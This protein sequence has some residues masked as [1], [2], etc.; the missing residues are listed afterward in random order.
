MVLS[1]LIMRKK[2]T[3]RVSWLFFLVL[4]L[5]MRS[6][7]SKQYR[8]LKTNFSRWIWLFF[9]ILVGNNAELYFS[10]HFHSH[11]IR[12][13]LF[14]CVQSLPPLIRIVGI[15]SIDIIKSMFV[16]C[17]SS[18]KSLA[19]RLVGHA[20]RRTCFQLFTCIYVHVLFHLVYSI[21]NNW[22]HMACKFVFSSLFRKMIFFFRLLEN[23]DKK[24]WIS[25]IKTSCTG[26]KNVLNSNE[27]SNS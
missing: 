20:M 2:S 14:F 22:H 23:L 21:R 27:V 11:L 6:E 24:K 17:E 4:N 9:L 25:F 18:E 26:M 16:T 10:E 3:T 7:L 13:N 1:R 5:A 12:D 19:V 15:G 8:K